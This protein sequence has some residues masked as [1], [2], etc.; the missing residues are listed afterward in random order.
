MGAQT[1]T[2]RGMWLCIECGDSLGNVV[3]GELHPTVPSIRTSGVNLVVTCPNCGFVKTWYTSDSSSRAVH[4]LIDSMASEM[5][6]AVVRNIGRE[7][8][9]K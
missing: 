5:A 6:A 3:G 1:Q 9:A 2:N 4:Q 8:H 7:M